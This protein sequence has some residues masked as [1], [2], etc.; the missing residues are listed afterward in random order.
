MRVLT[1]LWQHVPRSLR[2]AVKMSAAGILLVCIGRIVGIIPGARQIEWLIAQTGL[3]ISL[4]ASLIGAIAVFAH[5]VAVLTRA[6]YRIA[7][8]LT[9]LFMAAGLVLR[10]FLVFLVS[11]GDTAAYNLAE[12]ISI[13][14]AG[15]VGYFQSF[16]IDMIFVFLVAVPQL[17]YRIVPWNEASDEF[18]NHMTR[19]LGAGAAALTGIAAA[20]FYINNGPL[21]QVKPGVLVVA[22]LFAVALLVPI[23]RV[24]TI[25]CWRWGL[26]EL[27]SLRHLRQDWPIVVK[28]L[29]KARARLRIELEAGFDSGNAAAEDPALVGDRK[30]D[31]MVGL[32]GERQEA[33]EPPKRG[34][35]PT[36]SAHLGVVSGGDQQIGV[37]PANEGLK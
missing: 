11:G 37:A 30:N 5:L 8:M 33:G 24:V 34:Q 29:R 9:S 22:I 28:D 20:L 25:A 17:A 2:L 6:S 32:P 12:P 3:I 27:I 26:L 35:P 10:Y 31:L 18:K 13:V 16:A 15:W 36:G 7:V 1:S 4:C 21:A 19:W 14:K 23:Y